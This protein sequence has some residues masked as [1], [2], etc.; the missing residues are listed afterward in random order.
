MGGGGQVTPIFCSLFFYEVSK[1][2]KV[3]EKYTFTVVAQDMWWW[4]HMIC[5]GVSTSYAGSVAQDMCW[6]K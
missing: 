6:I 1:R 2:L 5:G 3:A 4:R